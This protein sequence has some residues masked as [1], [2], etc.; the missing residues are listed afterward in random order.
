M[1]HRAVIDG[2]WK[3]V[4]DWGRPW[5]L[6]NLSSD[7]TELHDLSKQQP[8]KMSQ[9]EKLWMEWWSTQNGK[10][11]KAAGDEPEYIPLRNPEETG[12]R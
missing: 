6:F 8:E 12:S 5:E 10:L 9:L 11:L 7:R 4:S 1:D 3:L 2:D